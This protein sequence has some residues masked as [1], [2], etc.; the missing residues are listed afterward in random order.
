MSVCMQGRE[1]NSVHCILRT[2]VYFFPHFPVVQCI[3]ITVLMMGTLRHCPLTSTPLNNS[4]FGAELIMYT[5]SSECMI[6]R[7]QI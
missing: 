7:Q 2:D 1:G 4:R 5:N 3:I 6:D